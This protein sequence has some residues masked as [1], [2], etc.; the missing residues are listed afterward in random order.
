M[1]RIAVF[2]PIVSVSVTIAVIAKPGACRSR[3]H[4]NFTSSQRA[5]TGLPPAGTGG[6]SGVMGAR[7]SRAIIVANASSA[8]SSRQAARSASTS[9]APR[10]S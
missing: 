3:R 10:A 2:A 1:L 6:G 9:E 7:R 8:S 5:R 4:A